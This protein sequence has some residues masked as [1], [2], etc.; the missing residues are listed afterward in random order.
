MGGNTGRSVIKGGTVS[1]NTGGIGND[2]GGNYQGSINNIGSLKEMQNRDL[3][4][5]VQQGISKF[6]SRLG[7]RSDV[8]LADLSGSVGVARTNLT[9][10]KTEVF[11]NRKHFEVATP[12]D[13]KAYKK[14]AYDSGFLT[15]TNKPTQH[16]V[17]HELSHALWNSHRR[18]EKSV[19]A[20]KDI[21]KVHKAFMRDNSSKYGSY[22]KTNINEFFAEVMTKGVLGKS[23]KYTNALFKIAKQN[24][25]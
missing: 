15:K 12:K 21:A 6:E 25:L 11:L 20:G 1:G 10:G 4:R 2:R 22:S 7:V 18:D 19:K 23:D 9:T 24:K 5:Q 17:V 14:R 13:V 3:Q 16:T 8:R